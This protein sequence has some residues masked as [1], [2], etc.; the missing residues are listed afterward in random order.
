MGVL[1][2]RLRTLDRSLVPPLTLNTSPN[3]SEVIVK[4]WN[5]WATFKIP[6]FSAQK[7][8]SAGG[9]GGPQ[10]FFWLE[11]SYFCY[12]GAHAKLENP[13]T[14][15]S[16]R[17]SNEPVE[18]KK[19][20]EKKMPFIVATYVYASS[21]GQCTHSARTNFLGWG[22]HKDWNHQITAPNMLRWEA[23]WYKSKLV[24][25]SIQNRTLMP[26]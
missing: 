18:K 10:I 2:H 3:P 14:I 25:I 13:K 11:S 16:G 9:R 21:Q 23:V 1:A 6:P 26:T 20:R 15:P 22:K 7:S 4:F 17:I 19:K 8:H 24:I 5:P 12:L